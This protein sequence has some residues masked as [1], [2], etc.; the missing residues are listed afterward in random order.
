MPTFRRESL[1]PVPA[2][3]L[4]DWH[5]R[6]GAFE[7]LAPPWQDI[8][9]TQRTGSIRNG[10][11]ITIR[12]RQGPVWLTWKAVHEGTVEG[13]E[14]T[15]RMTSGPFPEWIHRHHFAPGP[16]MATS[17]LRDVIQ[18][19]LPAG[20]LGEAV[21]GQKVAGDLERTFRFRHERTRLDLNQ[22]NRYAEHPRL[23]VGVTEWHTPR[24]RQLC[25]LLSTGGHS[26]Y[27]IGSKDAVAQTP[28]SDWLGNLVTEP[29]PLPPPGELIPMRAGGMGFE[30]NAAE[31]LDVVVVLPP[32]NLAEIL[33]FDGGPRSTV[34]GI[35]V[36]RSISL[37]AAI[38]SLRRPPPRLVLVSDVCVFGRSGQER[39]S[40]NAPTSDRKIPAFLAAVEESYTRL[41]KRGVSVAVARAGRSV[42]E[43]LDS[44][45]RVAW[46]SDDDLLDAILHL[47]YSSDTGPLVVASPNSGSRL[48]SDR[49]PRGLA[50]MSHDVSSYLQSVLVNPG[51][52]SLAERT[53]V[54]EPTTL[55]K[56]GFQFRY[57][58]LAEAGA[59]QLGL[60]SR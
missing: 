17:E 37:A 48:D 50:G 22:H 25:A 8:F 34:L 15:D 51:K 29:E 49:L 36:D 56:G 43:A 14:F 28:K 11:T 40:E 55:L 46:I 3:D 2:V 58:S 60:E 12:L 7:R 9:V 41:G 5:A 53:P 38:S 31:E 39:I 10:D 23:R 33:K 27:R 52:K 16:G 13:S 32:V 45:E 1:M 44:K 20:A 59:F 19:R 35:A 21:M 54:A 30:A 26:V 4:F 18:Y 57:A 6:D 47:A 42:I 24:G